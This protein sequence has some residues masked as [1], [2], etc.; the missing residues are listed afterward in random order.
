MD[1]TKNSVFM[2]FLNSKNTYKTME[3]I[4][5]QSNNG[6]VTRLELTFCLKKVRQSYS[7]TLICHVISETSTSTSL[8][9]IKSY[10]SLL[11]L[12]PQVRPFQE[13]SGSFTKVKRRF[14]GHPEADSNL[15]WICFR[16]VKS[17]FY[18]RFKVF[19]ERFLSF[20]YRAAH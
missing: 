9:K 2:S 11:K 16:S 20:T 5:S 3:K 17:F 1:T 10:N 19:M 13:V 6:K 18:E 4:L 15:F 7:H 8:L 12:V 14:P